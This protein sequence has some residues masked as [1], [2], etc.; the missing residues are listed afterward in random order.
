MKQIPPDALLLIAPGCPHCA[1][2]LASL[3]ELVKRGTVGRLE[4]VNIASHPEAAREAGTRTVPWTRIGSYELAGNY[5][6]G[7]LTSWAEKAAA[8]D[9]ANDYIKELLEQQQLEEAVAYLKKH[10]DQ[11][12]ALLELMQEE[13]QSLTVR[14][15]IGAI[16]EALAGSE[17]LQQLVPSLA[18][19]AEKGKANIRADAAHYL[20]LSGSPEAEPVLKKLLKDS[21]PDVREIAADSLEALGAQP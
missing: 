4:V 18:E 17:P 16:L 12:T 10:P 20:G 6:L 14:F 21:N 7:E 5:T 13:E 8:G 9:N 19:L 15:G 2:V 3:S 1:S 11:L